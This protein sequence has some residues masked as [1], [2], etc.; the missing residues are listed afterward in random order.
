MGRILFSVTKVTLTFDGIILITEILSQN[1]NS[2]KIFGKPNTS[3]L[4]NFS[5]TNRRRTSE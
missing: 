5:I 3:T 4:I 1:I 2:K